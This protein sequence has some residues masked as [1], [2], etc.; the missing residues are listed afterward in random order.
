MSGCNNC[1]IKIPVTRRSNSKYCSDICYRDAKRVRDKL[2]YKTSSTYLR[3]HK[4][5]ESILARLYPLCEKGDYN[6]PIRFFINEQFNWDRYDQLFMHEKKHFK[7][8]GS[9][10]YYVVTTDGNNQEVMICKLK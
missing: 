3:E 5:N 6:I 1:N 9:Y 10:A 7:R 4:I 8:V 2:N